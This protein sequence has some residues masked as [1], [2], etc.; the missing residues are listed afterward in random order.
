MSVQSRSSIAANSRLSPGTVLGGDFVIA[1]R[2]GGGAMGTVYLAEQRSTGRKRAVKVLNARFAKDPKGRERFAREAKLNAAVESDHVVEVIS[3]GVDDE[4]GVPWIA[5]ELLEGEELAG[6]VAK[7]PAL[8]QDECLKVLE[9]LG[10]GL[11]AAHRAGLVHRDLKPENVYLARSRRAGE[12]FTVKLLDF[13]LAK[14][15]S[16]HDQTGTFIGVGA[17]MW[18]APEQGQA[19]AA[20]TP[21]SDLWAFALLAFWLLTGKHYW[22]GAN[23]DGPLI[24]LIKEISAGVTVTATARATEL[25]VATKVP[26]G[27]DAWFARCTEREP[28]KRYRDADE[29]T[30]ALLAALRGTSS[31]TGG[32]RALAIVAIVTAVIVIAIAVVVTVLRMRG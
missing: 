27:F 22:K 25:G 12:D 32:G 6:R 1:S 19:K 2:I 17:P 31:T 14:L 9:Q 28:T 29:A 23:D 11:G 30:L 5:M 10:H 26:R 8:T 4:S 16:M 13:G 15:V 7:G 24:A 18:V 3:A 20:I 21:A